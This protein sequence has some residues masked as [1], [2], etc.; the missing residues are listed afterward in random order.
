MAL[1]RSGLKELLGVVML[2]VHPH[3]TQHNLQLTQLLLEMHLTNISVSSYM[4]CVLYA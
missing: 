3:T 1:T 2:V 4:L